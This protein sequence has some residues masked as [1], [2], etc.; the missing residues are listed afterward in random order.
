MKRSLM[1]PGLLVVGLVNLT[2]CVGPT[3]TDS[4]SM[5]IRKH[6]VFVSADEEYRSEESLPML[7]A[8]LE[9][10]HPIR[11]TILY[12]I[13]KD[14]GEIDPEAVDNLPGLEVLA[15]ADL[16]VFFMRY[17]AIPDDQLRHILDYCRAGGP[18]AAFRTTN[19]AFRYRAFEGDE[20]KK[21]DYGF[22]T[23]FFGQ[24]FIG[25]QGGQTDVT[26]VDAEKEHPI[27]R[28]VMPVH[29]R[30]WL[31][32]AS[33][34]EHALDPNVTPLLI[35]HPVGAEF[36]KPPKSHPCAW[37][38]IDQRD[39][40]EK[41]RVFYTSLGHCE[42]FQRESVRKLSINAFLWCLGLEDRIPASGADGAPVGVY[43]PTPSKVGGHKRGVFPPG[44]KASAR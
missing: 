23:E 24:R 16:V 17:R 35:G 41:V 14:T 30:S 27:L 6:V 38:R 8:I 29:C 22:G 21:W 34:E 10:D 1:F 9:R 31:Y 4:E 42:D 39:G 11:T 43:D 20:R 13:R 37:Y 25:Y 19:H 33:N 18:R 15:T 44:S 32:T 28:G 12:S 2:G 36:P 3:A 26:L 7:A 40:G 5:E